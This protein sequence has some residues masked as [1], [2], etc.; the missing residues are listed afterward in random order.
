AKMEE[1]DRVSIRYEHRPGATLQSQVESSDRGLLDLLRRQPLSVAQLAVEIQVTA[2]AVRQRLARLMAQGLVQRVT[3]KAARGRPSHCYSLTEKAQR[4]TGSNFS[5]LAIALWQEIRALKDPQVR[6]GLLSRVANT[7]ANQYASQIEGK[8]TAERMQSVVAIFAER[9][10]PLTVEIQDQLPVLTILACP[11]PA[12]AE[13][14]RGI[15][16]FEKLLFSELLG[17]SVRLKD[18]RLD[19]NDCCRFHTS[20]STDIL[21]SFAKSDVGEANFA[22]NEL[23]CQPVSG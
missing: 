18:C 3:T 5:D 13:R 8:N 23:S 10:I 14:D 11:Y 19:G 20:A 15:C 4:Q 12:L 2:T 17:E 16:A 1:T 21:T 22:T 9:D 7:V 6:S